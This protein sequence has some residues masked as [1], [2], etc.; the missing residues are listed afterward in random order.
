[1]T[2]ELNLTTIRECCGLAA[3]LTE[4]YRDAATV[5][6]DRFHGGR[7]APTAASI[8]DGGGSI[9]PASIGW[10]APTEAAQ[11]W[12]GFQTIPCESLWEASRDQLPG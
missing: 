10:S 1:M 2:I 5:L 6:L 8:E 7:G 4:A 11:S 12:S 9:S 3:N